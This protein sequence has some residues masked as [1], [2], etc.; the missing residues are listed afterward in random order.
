MATA[1]RSSDTRAA[2]GG[3][4]RLSYMET[5]SIPSS[6]ATA[7]RLAVLLAEDDP[8]VQGL[9]RL[10][11]QGHAITSTSASEDACNEM[12][13]NR[14]DVVITDLRL[15]DGDGFQ[16]IRHAVRTQP[17]A[18]LIVMTGTPAAASKESEELKGVGPYVRLQKPFRPRELRDLIAEAGRRRLDKVGLA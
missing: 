18:F 7:S 12:A 5:A 15:L 4:P 10:C 13:R 9:I 2:V 16:V 3:S 17:N 1:F 11:L 8:H 14:Y 6:S